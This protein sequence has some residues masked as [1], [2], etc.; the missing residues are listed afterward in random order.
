MKDSG[1]IRV[2]RCIAEGDPHE[3]PEL[4]FEDESR[5]ID[6]AKAGDRCAFEDL[7]AHYG[8]N[9]FRFV[10]GLVGDQHH[11]EDIAQQVWVNAHQK[12][13]Q[14]DPAKGSFSTWVFRIARNLSLNHL[15]GKSRSPIQFGTPLP[16]L[17][18]S[19]HSPVTE[20]IEEQ[21]ALLDAALKQLPVHQR[22][23]WTLSEVEGL[24]QAQIAEIE[25]V[26]EG[27]IKSRVSRAKSALQKTVANHT[28]MER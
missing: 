16:D 7:L 11:A 28:E 12:L 22:A 3:E 13:S 18:D 19:C 26:P 9:I 5:L 27:T 23:A 25:G 6:R 21:F 4:D 10:C 8:N 1:T 15:R 2:F 24:S 20:D 14:F 17:H